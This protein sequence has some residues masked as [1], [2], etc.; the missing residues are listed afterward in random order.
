MSLHLEEPRLAKQPSVFAKDLDGE[1]GFFLP[2]YVH[3]GFYDRTL[4]YIA[5]TGAKPVWKEVLSFTHAMEIVAYNFGVALLPRSVARHSHMGVLFKPI[6]DKLLWIETALFPR[7][8]R[9]DNR[10]QDL[11]H[12]LLSEL[13]SFPPSS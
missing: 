9:K 6:T 10:V 7:Q 5:S 4:E 12:A 2:R 8:E 11:L 13:K 3:P 1:M